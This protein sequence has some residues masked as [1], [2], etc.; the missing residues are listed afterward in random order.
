MDFKTLIGKIVTGVFD[1]LVL[2]IVGGAVIYFLIGILKCIQSVG[3][4]AKRKEGGT[5]MTYGVIALFVM[6]TVWGLVHA[7][8]KTFNLDPTPIR[9]PSTAGP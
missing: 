3:D 8:E 2:V 4:E 7:L 6:V 9:P 5:M 1:P